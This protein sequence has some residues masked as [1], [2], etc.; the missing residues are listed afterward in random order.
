MTKCKCYSSYTPLSYLWAFLSLLAALLCSIGL[1][2][3][4]WLQRET[5]EGTYNSVSPFRLCLNES[6]QLSMSCDA[7]LSFNE[8][9]SSHWKAVTL[10][11][12]FGA[13][14]SVL[15]ALLALFGLCVQKLF[16]F[17]VTGVAVSSQGLAG[18]LLNIM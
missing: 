3:S 14:L 18:E 9:Y 12:G 6:S 11:M 8:M 5:P 16:N 4:N 1:Y 17:F 2:F 15:S 7:Y 13:C 10:L